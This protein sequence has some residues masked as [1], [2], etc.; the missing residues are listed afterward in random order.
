[1]GTCGRPGRWCRGRRG[2]RGIFLCRKLGP[3]TTQRMAKPVATPAEALTRPVTR[4]GAESEA[5]EDSGGAKHHMPR[6]RARMGKPS[7]SEEA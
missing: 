5:D 6:A 3:E 2:Y 1:M 4:P 7:Y